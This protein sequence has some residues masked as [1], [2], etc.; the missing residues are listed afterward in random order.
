MHPRRYLLS[1]WHQGKEPMLEFQ[2]FL[3]KRSYFQAIKHCLLKLNTLSFDTLSKYWRDMNKG[4][5]HLLSCVH[6]LLLPVATVGRAGTQLPSPPTAGSLYSCCRNQGLVSVQG[7][8]IS[9]FELLCLLSSSQQPPEINYLLVILCKI[10]V[11][12]KM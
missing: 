6:C 10:I 4:S 8:N 3:P 9:S 5:L 11:F 7:R 2:Y 1:H 12:T